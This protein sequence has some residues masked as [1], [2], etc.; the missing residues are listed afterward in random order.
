[1]G[2]TLGKEVSRILITIAGIKMRWG[3]WYLIPS[4]I[5]YTKI[6]LSVNS[7][8]KKGK[9]FFII[10]NTLKM[11]VIPRKG[12]SGGTFIRDGSEQNPNIQVFVHCE[13]VPM[14]SKLCSWFLL[15]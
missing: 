9:S 8:V 4:S 2:N 7:R 5:G 15:L 14:G 12:R 13:K 6:H 3:K 1:M 10:Q 11:E